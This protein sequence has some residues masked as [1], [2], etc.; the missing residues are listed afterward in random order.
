MPFGCPMCRVSLRLL[1]CV[2]EGRGE[3]RGRGDAGESCKGEGK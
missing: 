2:G 1:C 3:K